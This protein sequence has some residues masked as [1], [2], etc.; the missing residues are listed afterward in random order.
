MTR[1][2]AVLL[3]LLPAWAAAQE[4]PTV[5]GYT[6]VSSARVTRTQFDFV[7][8]ASLTNPLLGDLAAV[9][10]TL[11]S[12]SPATQ[13]I[14]GTLSFGDVAA[15][16]TAASQDTFTIRQ[17]RTLPFSP[18]NL[19]W[20]VG[21]RLAGEPSALA[22]D[23]ITTLPPVGV[24][25]IDI[26]EGVILTRLDVFLAP[27]SSSSDVNAALDSVGARIVSMFSGGDGVTIAVPRQTGIDG[28]QALAQTL[29][30]FPVVRLAIPAMPLRADQLAA[31]NDISAARH[32][33]PMR[34]P[35]A[36]N[37]SNLVLNCVK[38]ALV[39]QDQFLQ[40]PAG[41]DQLFPGFPAPAP[42]LATGDPT[43]DQHGYHMF[44]VAAAPLSLA[45]SPGA[46]PFI[47]CLDL[48]PIQTA[49]SNMS[50]LQ[51][52]VDLALGIPVTGKS[53]VSYSLS[54]NSFCKTFDPVKNRMV[55]DVC[56]PTAANEIVTPLVRAQVALEWK[57]MTRARWP[58]FLVAASA[59]NDRNSGPLGADIYPG[60]TRAANTSA[61]ALAAKADPLFAFAM[62]A[63]QWTPA[64]TFLS[65]GFV[66]LVP[67]VPEMDK[68][69]ADVRAA[70]LDSV[71][72]DNVVLVGGVTTLPGDP[73]TD[74]PGYELL[75][76]ADFSN[77]DPDVKV[78]A[79]NVAGVC[80]SL[81][82][83]ADDGNSRAA[84]QVAGLVTYL[85]ALS[86]DLRNQPASVTRQAIIENVRYDGQ[87]PGIL[88]AYATV[89]SLDAAALPDATN[90]PVRKAI[91]DVDTGGSSA[92]VFDESDI[93]EFLK[94]FFF[95]A[96]GNPV[97]EPPE[98]DFGRYDLNGDGFTGGSH[99]ERFDL[100]RLGSTRFGPTLYG[101]VT[102]AV[103]GTP[104]QFDENALSDLDVLCYS[105]YSD[106]YQ[107]DANF[108]RQLL[109]QLPGG[110]RCVPSGIFIP[111]IGLF[112][113][114]ETPPLGERTC[115][116]SLGSEPPYPPLPTGLSLQCPRSNV[117]ISASQA[118]PNTIV[119]DGS[120]SVSVP[121]NAVSRAEGSIT[122]QLDY[123]AF[124]TRYG[125]NATLTSSVT[126]NGGW[127][128]DNSFTG[129]SG[130]WCRVAINSYGTTSVPSPGAY[131]ISETELP[132]VSR[133][134][135]S[136][137]GVPAI[138]VS[139]LCKRPVGS[140]H[141]SGSGQ[142]AT[143]TFTVVP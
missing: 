40:K 66:S 26:A 97:L 35:A 9:Q 100:D 56:N 122:L 103:E 113:E 85:W 92:G 121:T 65:Q 57:K 88:D 25:P 41:F 15:G 1:A 51:E 136:Y 126:L 78:V 33:V 110:F 96:I 36:W 81:P 114:D 140:A 99:T 27:D 82:C 131:Y 106:L 19:V 46:N 132:P 43:Q 42:A 62:D 69:R 45:K 47:H 128:T 108:R 112:A 22:H 28:L 137:L 143:I 90:A 50:A 13:V 94:H 53:V 87:T 118:G 141:A 60:V 58:S 104:V 115:I 5:S 54:F 21:V 84:P 73:K 29:M 91:L 64:Q 83:A 52:V 117:A 125:P 79:K 101:T 11:A 3:L 8:R 123:N 24:E 55:I 4:R 67:S 30:S 124:V 12:R 48:K 102:Q 71:V 16:V 133:L 111:N 68:L 129:L 72:A 98:A 31:S 7:Y 139:L 95:D 44:A 134:T 80:T 127:V 76:E 37:A 130:P 6:L 59:S 70:G 18:G 61:F 75:A 120:A 138:G 119:V 23:A 39:I 2:L 10:A 135:E 142:I 89:L 116:K 74:S 49:A 38:V 105:A 17:D 77:S 63:S 109:S 93:D 86:P 32:L 14:E 34:F 107:G 20:S